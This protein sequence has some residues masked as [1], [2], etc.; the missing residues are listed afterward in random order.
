MEKN[1]LENDETKEEPVWHANCVAAAREKGN[2]FRQILL[3]FR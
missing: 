2:L 1:F 3:N